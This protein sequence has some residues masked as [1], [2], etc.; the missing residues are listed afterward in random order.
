MATKLHRGTT[1]TAAEY[2]EEIKEL[3]ECL[4]SVPTRRDA[5]T[6]EFR[7][8]AFNQVINETGLVPTEALELITDGNFQWI[9]NAFRY[10]NEL[11]AAI[12]DAI[13]C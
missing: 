10:S 5:V 4:L 7:V 9:D 2:V 8:M 12:D 3:A 13:G 1:H 11:S 6:I